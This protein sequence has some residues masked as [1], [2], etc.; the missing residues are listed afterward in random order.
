MGIGTKDPKSKSLKSKDIEEEIKNLNQEDRVITQIKAD[1]IDGT[2]FTRK[3][4][5]F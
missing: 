4:I 5:I 3:L 1:Q 2:F